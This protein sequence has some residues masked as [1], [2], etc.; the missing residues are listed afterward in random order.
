MAN[1]NFPPTSRYYDT[2]VKTLTG[3]DGENLV[4][5]ARRFLPPSGAFSPIGVH[6]VLEG[7]RPDLVA[8]SELG[9]PLAF[10]RLCDANDAMRP[11]ELTERLGRRLRI[12]LPLGVPGTPIA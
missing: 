6:M 4:Y 7:E 5:L 10:W 11:E 3:S 9:D 1:Y 8:A 12:T 2:P